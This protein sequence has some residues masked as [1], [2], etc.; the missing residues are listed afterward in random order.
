MA[1]KRKPKLT[2]EQTIANK[3]LEASRKALQGEHDTLYRMD[4][5]TPAQ[6]SQ[7]DVVLAARQAVAGLEAEYEKL[8]IKKNA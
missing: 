1:K 2:E 8:F 4:G 3:K 7:V 6:R 5:N